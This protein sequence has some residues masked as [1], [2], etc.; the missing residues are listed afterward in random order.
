MVS[1]QPPSNRRIAFTSPEKL[2]ARDAS[3]SRWSSGTGMTT[4]SLICVISV[5]SLMPDGGPS[6]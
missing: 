6:A 1:R 3:S 5:T 4:S 2:A